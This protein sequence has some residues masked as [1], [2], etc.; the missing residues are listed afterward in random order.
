MGPPTQRARRTAKCA[1][2]S[3]AFDTPSLAAIVQN[4]LP[5]LGPAF[6]PKLA[7]RAEAVAGKFKAQDVAN[8]MWARAT[9]ERVPGAGLM[10]ELETRA[11]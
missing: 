9:M 2:F 4:A 3:G 8:T 1:D 7:G 6:V 10:R 5:P 11:S